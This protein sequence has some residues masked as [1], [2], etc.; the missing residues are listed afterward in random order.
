MKKNIS[1]ILSI[2]F[3]VMV[4][5]GIVW[6]D[7]SRWD[8]N[9]K[10]SSDGYNLDLVSDVAG[11]TNVVSVDLVDAVTSIT[12]TV[13]TKETL[14]S[15][16][17]GL[18]LAVVGTTAVELAFTGD[19]KTIFISSVTGNTGQMYIGESTVTNAGVGAMYVLNPN[20]KISFDYND[21]SNAIYVVSSVTPTS[22][23]AGAILQ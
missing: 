7:G 14:S 10:R 12:N 18:G 2:V 5:S 23:I 11:V 17:E 6:A 9:I 8:T 3:A 4:V 16:I 15:D 1:L 21:S 20:D 22:Y 19:T 13:T